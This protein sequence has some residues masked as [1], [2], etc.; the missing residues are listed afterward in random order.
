MKKLSMMV[1]FCCLLAGSSFAQKNPFFTIGP[2]F[3]IN[4]SNILSDRSSPDTDG[5]LAYQAG[6]FARLGFMKTY[7]QPEAY[8]NFKSTSIAF[9]DGSGATNFSG[10]IRFNQIDVPVL[11]GSKIIN[12][13]IFNLRFFA[14][15]M[16]SFLLKDENST[17][18][19]DPNQYDFNNKI[20]GGQAGL[21]LDIGNITV[22][23]RYQTKL[24]RISS[25]I[26]GPESML[27]LSAGIKLF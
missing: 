20:W 1:V 27:H 13:K 3:G 23:L 7:V 4:Y 2:K 10:Q 18:N 25:M 21:G 17:K 5:I 26:S 24:S 19:Y 12:A 22:D 9:D 14:G 8:Y 11:L 16:V 6:A 15:P